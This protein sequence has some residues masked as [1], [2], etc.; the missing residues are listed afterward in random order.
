MVVWVNFESPIWYRKA[1]Y[2]EEESVSF[3]KFALVKWVTKM[4]NQ[5]LPPRICR[6]DGPGSRLIKSNRIAL[7]S[8]RP[9]SFR[10]ESISDG[11]RNAAI[12]MRALCGC[13]KDVGRTTKDLAERSA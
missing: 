9:K 8:L 2:K 6:I 4:H 13:R 11:E 5:N 1:R 10:S 3:S 12:R 7:W